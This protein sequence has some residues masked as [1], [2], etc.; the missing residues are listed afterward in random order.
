[1][2]CERVWLLLGLYLNKLLLRVLNPTTY[3]AEWNVRS[4]NIK[5][6]RCRWLPAKWRVAIDLIA[7]AV[8]LHDVARCIKPALICVSKSRHKSTAIFGMNIPVI[9]YLTA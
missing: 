3:E 9:K 4:P 6:A 8:M 7:V 5:A 1:M 2:T